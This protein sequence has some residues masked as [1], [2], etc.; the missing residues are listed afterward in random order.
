MTRRV[1]GIQKYMLF[2]L[3]VCTLKKITIALK[4]KILAILTFLMAALD[5]QQNFMLMKVFFLLS[6]RSKAIAFVVKNLPWLN[7]L[8]GIAIK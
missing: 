5:A 4:K 1:S 8:S 2:C 7:I 3:N 6:L